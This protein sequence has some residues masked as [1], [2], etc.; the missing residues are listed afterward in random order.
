MLPFARRLEPAVGGSKASP[1]RAAAI[2]TPDGTYPAPKAGERFGNF[3]WKGSASTE[4]IGEI[5]EFNYGYDVR[6]FLFPGAPVGQDKL[7]S[8]GRLWT[9]RTPWIWRVWSINR[10]GSIVLSDTRQFRN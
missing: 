4:V 6:L 10:D 2:L 3:A 1:L 7:L 5:A 8:T 9:T